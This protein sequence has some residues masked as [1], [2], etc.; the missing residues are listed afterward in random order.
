MG[1]YKIIG[2]VVLPI[3]SP[4]PA[5]TPNSLGV[6]PDGLDDVGVGDGRASLSGP[7]NAGG[8]FVV[9]LP[10]D[11]VGAVRGRRNEGQSLRL[12]SRVDC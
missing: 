11:R 8:E 9:H 12:G 6:D 10:P 5:P 2:D 3:E 1:Y 4:D 7:K